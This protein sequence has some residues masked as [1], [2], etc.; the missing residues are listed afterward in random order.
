MRSTVS[1]TPAF[2]A[3]LH[4][5]TD[6]IVR[7]AMHKTLAAQP[8]SSQLSAPL[9]LRAAAWGRNPE[10]EHTTPPIIVDVS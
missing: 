8:W 3:M 2:K 7:G 5:A 9:Q 6:T 4:G 10:F 1:S